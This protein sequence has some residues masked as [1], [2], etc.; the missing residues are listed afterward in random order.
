MQK[1]EVQGHI[2]TQRHYGILG[3]PSFWRAPGRTGTHKDTTK[4]FRRCAASA[5]VIT[6]PSSAQPADS[7]PAGSFERKSTYDVMAVSG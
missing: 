1:P 4:P 7:A 2:R 5:P 3:Y 6:A